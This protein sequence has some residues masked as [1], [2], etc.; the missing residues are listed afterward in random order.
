MSSGVKPLYPPQHSHMV[1][2]DPAFG[3]Q[4]FHVAVPSGFVDQRGLSD[5]GQPHRQPVQH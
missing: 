5:L 2:S 1:D 4:L 3:Q